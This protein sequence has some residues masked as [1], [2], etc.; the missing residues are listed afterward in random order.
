MPVALSEQ[1]RGV[2][3]TPADRM[4][5]F[6]RGMFHFKPWYDEPFVAMS[7]ECDCGKLAKGR[8]GCAICRKRNKLVVHAVDQPYRLTAEEWEEAQESRRECQREHG[9]RRR[10]RIKMNQRLDNGEVSC[11]SED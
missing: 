5:L 6:L 9:R 8:N 1:L 3:L 11:Q 10:Q 7:G 4:S 2:A